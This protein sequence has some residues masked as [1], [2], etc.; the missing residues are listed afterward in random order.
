VLI[1]FWYVFFGKKNFVSST[2]WMSDVEPNGVL[3]CSM[4]TQD[5]EKGLLYVSGKLSG[6]VNKNG[7][8]YLALSDI[9]KIT[10][11][12]Q[13]VVFIPII[14]S[15]EDI[16]DRFNKYGDQVNIDE[17][18]QAIY[19]NGVE[20]SSAKFMELVESVRRNEKFVLVEG[21]LGLIETNTN[22]PFYY[23]VEVNDI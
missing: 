1:V 16:L 22:V 5:I 2:I 3:Y 18:E 10:D 23:K 15:K 6:L 7:V 9:K 20:I 21:Y 12:E 14:F 4:Y 13:N 17:V 8:Y 19:W 11:D